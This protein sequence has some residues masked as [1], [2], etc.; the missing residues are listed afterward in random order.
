MMEIL[1]AIFVIS[2]IA[3]VIVSAA[4]YLGASTDP[5]RQDD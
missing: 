1:F 2:L 5:R 4:G 3:S